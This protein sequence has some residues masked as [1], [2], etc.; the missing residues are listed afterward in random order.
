M[1]KVKLLIFSLALPLIVGFISSYFTVGSIPTWYASLNKPSFN[2]PNYIFAPVWTILYI[3]MGISLYLIL[4][5][6]KNNKYG[7]MLF[8]V[9]LALNFAWS[10]VFFGT[11]HIVPAFI[12]IVLLWIAIFMTIKEF[13][14][15]NKTAGYLLIPYILWVSFATILN[16]SIVLLNK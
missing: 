4:S 14:K 2:P 7:L 8:F 16:L 5:S 6:K 15:I 1:T 12:D 3:L 10:L 13:L 9:Q 11:H